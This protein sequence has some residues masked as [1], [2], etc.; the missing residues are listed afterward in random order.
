MNSA[1][2]LAVPLHSSTLLSAAYDDRIAVLELQ[3]RDGT[4]YRYRDVPNTIYR[5]LLAAT[6]QGGFFNRHIRGI[7]AYAKLNPK[8]R[9]RSL[10]RTE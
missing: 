7:F 6:S 9:C 8:Q 3:F 4:C 1:L 5:N 10:Y 2:P